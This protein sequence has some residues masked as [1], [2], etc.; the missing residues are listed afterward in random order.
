[1]ASSAPSLVVIGG[2]NGAGKST[3]AG[4]LLRDTLAVTEFVNADVLARGLSGFRPE[5]SAV[6]AGRVMLARLRELA[7]KRIDFAFETTMASRSFAPW[8]KELAASG[9]EI[10][11]VF[12]WL[13][14][15][16]LAVQ[17]V[18]ERVRAG[19][20]DVP[21]E[22]IRRRFVRGIRNFVGLYRPLAASW[23]VYDNSHLTGPRQI[24][25]GRGIAVEEVLDEQRWQRFQAFAGTSEETPLDP[26]DD[27]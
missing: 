27:D 15:A 14:T 12:L 26:R 1:M 7:A 21:E 16:D 13:P 8:L 3:A 20:H 10:H 24:A 11:L 18:R 6:A 9:Y 25:S 17:R 19:G 23:R 4:P 2:P 5:G 22:T